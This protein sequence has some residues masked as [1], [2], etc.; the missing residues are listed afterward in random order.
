GERNDHKHQA[1]DE[2][3]GCPLQVAAGVPVDGGLADLTD[4]LRVGGIEVLLDLGE[5]ALFVL[6]KRHGD[7]PLRRSN[8]VLNI[9]GT[10]NGSSTSLA[11][12]AGFDN[13]AGHRS[14]PHWV[15]PFRFGIVPARLPGT[16]AASPKRSRMSSTAF[17]APVH[18]GESASSNVS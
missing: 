18:P 7:P 3:K 8:C 5:D 6:G 15:S 13:A 10:P 1:P 16:M 14:G 4:E 11:R 12:N 9:S 17:V 2:A